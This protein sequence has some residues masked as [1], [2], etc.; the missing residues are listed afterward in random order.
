MQ[1]TQGTWVQSLG[2]EA[3]P[4]GRNGNLSSI[5]CMQTSMDRGA[6]QATVHGITK[7]WTQLSLNAL[8]PQEA[9]LGL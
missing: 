9:S 7:S 6:G 1:E 8:L 5:L 3:S 4:G 2:W